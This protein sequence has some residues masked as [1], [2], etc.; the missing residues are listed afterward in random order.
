VKRLLALALA[1]CHGLALAQ[2]KSDWE[3]EEERRNWK[4]REIQLP[5]YPRSG[6]LAEFY[7]SAGTDFR[8]FI[9]RQSIS[10]GA[11]GVVRYTSVA[12]S[13][14][15]AE[16]VSY[17]GIRC[18]AG[19]VRIYAHGRPGATWSRSESDWRP[20]EQKAL[21]RY[22]HALWSDYFCPHRVPIGDVREGLDALVRGGHPNVGAGAA[23]MP[24]VKY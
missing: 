8:F 16:N 13:S 7:V 21:Q 19:M 17:E 6:N 3:I 23:G 9:D 14:S 10:V 18:S 4:E 20:I 15:G 1:A 22:H 2:I 11:D 24:D 5:A 12:R